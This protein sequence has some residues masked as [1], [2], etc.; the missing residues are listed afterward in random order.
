MGK[1]C[2][3]Q[4]NE[5]EDN[6]EEEEGRASVDSITSFNTRVGLRARLFNRN[7][8]LVNKVMSNEVNNGQSVDS[9]FSIIDQNNINI[10]I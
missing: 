2:E 4:N 1:T 6:D 3:K 9:I 8:E 5:G 7:K 10:K